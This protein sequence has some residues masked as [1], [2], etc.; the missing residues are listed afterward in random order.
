MEYTDDQL[1]DLY[2]KGYKNAFVSI[3]K[4][5][6]NEHRKKLFNKIKNMGF[7]T[8]V[9]ISKSANVSRYSEIGEGTLIVK[10]IVINPGTQIGKNCIINTGSIIEHDCII[11]DNVHIGPGAILS[12]GTHIG[13]NSFIGTGAI[14]IQNINISQDTLIGA[15]GV[16]VK[17]INKPGVYVGN[18]AKGIK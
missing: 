9:I 16:V 12:G 2:K 17:D 11:E 13:K 5:E 10:N 1:E 8:P 14:I 15:G 18:P 3:G 7:N 6:I 4:V